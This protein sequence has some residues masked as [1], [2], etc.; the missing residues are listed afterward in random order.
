MTAGFRYHDNEQTLSSNVTPELD[1]G[2]VLVPNF[3]LLSLASFCDP[4]RHAADVADWSRQHLCR[5]TFLTTDNLPATSS[6]GIPVAPWENFGD[7]FDFDYLIV[8]GGRLDGVELVPPEFHEYLREAHQRGVS[9][10]AAC[11]G[12]FVLGDAGLLDGKRCAV[13]WR[14]TGKFKDRFPNAIPDSGTSYIYSDGI[15]SCSSG[16]SSMYMSLALVERHCG[17]SRALKCIDFMSAS[18]Q[19]ENLP[20]RPANYTD[21]EISGNRNLERAVSLM[22]HWMSSNRKISEVAQ[23]IGISRRQ[24]ERI[25]DAHTG[26]SPIVFWRRLR[27]S[28]GR[29]ALSN[30]SKS[31]TEIAYECGFSDAS[32]F[33]RLFKASYKENPGSFRKSSQSA[34]TMMTETPTIETKNLFAQVGAQSTV[35]PPQD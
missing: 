30:T 22:N 17:R 18:V 9:L 15:Y 10:G 32:H 35:K 25:F 1:V 26:V 31:I 29:W 34:S 28:H 2:I 21:L 33:S 6:A 7:R 12:T 11:F 5:W 27:L 8:I 14:D 3:S 13:H 16:V 23:E 20:E 24:L 19:L 4:L